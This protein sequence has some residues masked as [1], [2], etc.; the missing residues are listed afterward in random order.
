MMTANA[1]SMSDRLTKG[2]L[3]L[4]LS[5]TVEQAVPVIQA[6]RAEAKR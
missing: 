4:L 5:G 3:G 6:G 2:Y 1:A